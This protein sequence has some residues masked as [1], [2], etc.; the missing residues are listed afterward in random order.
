MDKPLALEYS[1]EK[2]WYSYRMFESFQAV[3]SDSESNRKFDLK[4]VVLLLEKRKR[5][6]IKTQTLMIH[7]DLQVAIRIS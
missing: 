6:I 1:G 5:I 7:F 4:S 2:K 3:Q